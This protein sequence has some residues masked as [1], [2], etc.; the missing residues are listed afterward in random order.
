MSIEFHC[1]GCGKLLRTSDDAAGR[2]AQCPACGAVLTVGDDSVGG[3]SNYVP[4]TPPPLPRAPSG[5]P[6]PADGMNPFQA[7]S[8]PGTAPI[9]GGDPRG[10]VAGPAIALMVTA[11]LGAI[12]Y[13]IYVL[14]GLLM[15]VG[16]VPIQNN[17]QD[18]RFTGALLVGMYGLG[19][20][21][22]S[23]T[24]YGALKMKSL[25]SYALAMTSAILSMIP[26]GCCILGIPF[27]IWALVVI[28]DQQVRDA[29]KR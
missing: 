13:A 19:L 25:E 14:I 15:I 6:T 29:F 12:F 21:C 9:V 10:R 2:Q 23:I 8:D 28:N 16:V 11:A 24:Y 27:G 1:T 17:G 7:P 22:C 3:P 5:Y 26:C 4:S 18:P 20:A